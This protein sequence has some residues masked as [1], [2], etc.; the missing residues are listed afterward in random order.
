MK[1]IVNLLETGEKNWSSGL[2]P[3]NFNSKSK[4]SKQK[5]VLTLTVSCD[6]SC[7]IKKKS[8]KEMNK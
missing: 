7:L 6:K 1:K 4:T 3:Y 2:L 8:E 5:N